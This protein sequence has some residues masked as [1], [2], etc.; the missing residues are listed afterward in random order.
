MRLSNKYPCPKCGAEIGMDCVIFSH[1]QPARPRKSTYNHHERQ[2]LYRKNEGPLP[3]D[4]KPLNSRVNNK[5]ELLQTMGEALDKY[6]E[7]I[8]KQSYLESISSLRPA[9]GL[10]D[11]SCRAEALRAEIV[12]AFS[13]ALG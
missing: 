8:V 3:W 6:A 9:K 4:P 11:V 12:E 10:H 2:E 5:Q 7:L 1:R 13:I